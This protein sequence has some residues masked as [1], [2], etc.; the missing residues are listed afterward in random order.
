[1][2]AGNN[3]AE[4]EDPEVFEAAMVE[5]HKPQERHQKRHEDCN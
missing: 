5:K 1:M 3:Q 2:A 4:L